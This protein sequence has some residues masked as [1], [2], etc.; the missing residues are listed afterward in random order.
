[1]KE[2]RAD[3]SGEVAFPGVFPLTLLVHCNE[4]CKDL[5]YLYR[6]DIAG[7]GILKRPV[8]Y[9]GALFLIAYRYAGLVFLSC[10]RRCETLPFSDEVDDV[11]IDLMDLFTDSIEAHSYFSVLFGNVKRDPMPS[12]VHGRYDVLN[13][14]ENR[15]NTIYDHR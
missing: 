12:V 13:R 4:Y 7:D 5:S 14:R 3:A 2:S 15:N 1:M 8:Q 11:L 6:V 10:H 9:A